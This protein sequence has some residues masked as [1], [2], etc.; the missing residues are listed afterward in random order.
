MLYDSPLF[1]GGTKVSQ[2]IHD[3][4]AHYYGFSY[5]KEFHRIISHIGGLDNHTAVPAFLEITSALTEMHYTFS[6]DEIG[7]IHIH[8]ESDKNIE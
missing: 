5:D 1:I 6:V 7:T 8:A 3:L 4:V 2:R